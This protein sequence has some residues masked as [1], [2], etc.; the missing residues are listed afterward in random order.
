M[1]QLWTLVSFFILQR[2]NVFLLRVYRNDY[3]LRPRRKMNFLPQG[4]DNVPTTPARDRM[5]HLVEKILMQLQGELKNDAATSSEDIPQPSAARSDGGSP[6]LPL[7]AYSARGTPPP[8]ETACSAVGSLVRY[9]RDASC[10]NPPKPCDMFEICSSTIQICR[11][12]TLNRPEKHVVLTF[13]G[14][15]RFLPLRVLLVDDK[16]SILKRL[17]RLMRNRAYHYECCSNAESSIK[18]FEQSL[19]ERNVH[20]RFDLIL[21]DKEMPESDPEL[22]KSSGVAAVRRIRELSRLQMEQEPNFKSPCIIGVTSCEDEDDPTLIQ[23][24][25]ELQL[26]RTQAGLRS[27]ILIQRKLNQWSE[28]FDR[29]V[30]E[31]CGKS[32]ASLPETDEAQVEPVVWGD[33]TRIEK[34]LRNLIMNAIKHGRPLEGEHRVTLSYDIV[35]WR[36]SLHPCLFLFERDDE[37][38][39]S[40]SWQLRFNLEDRIQRFVQVMVTDNGPGLDGNSARLRQTLGLELPSTREFELQGAANGRGDASPSQHDPPSSSVSNFGIGLQRIVCREVA[41][42][43]GAM[44]VH[45]RSEPDTGCTFVIALPLYAP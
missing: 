35:D 13:A 7:E 20:N 36:T 10:S 9:L 19:S 32:V 21:M 31:L 18:A 26:S 5:L 24:R 8:L 16:E 3:Q 6:A 30:R 11:A 28:E 23:F 42:N 15:Q 29:E 40:L 37:V 27:N 45:S 25:H 39:R 41:N 12:V 38:K 34:I 14:R 17:Q 33:R 43:H 2:H 22:T 44:G 4:D 1:A